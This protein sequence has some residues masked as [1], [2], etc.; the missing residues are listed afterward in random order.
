MPFRWSSSF[1]S[2]DWSLA[3]LMPNPILPVSIKLRP[4]LIIR[5][6]T[7]SKVIRWFIQSHTALVR[8]VLLCF[9]MIRHHELLWLGNDCFLMI[10]SCFSWLIYFYIFHMFFISYCSLLT[11]SHALFDM[12]PSP[13][14]H[15][16]MFLCFTLLQ[17]QVCWLF[18][19]CG[20]FGTRVIPTI[21]DFLD[22]IRYSRTL[23]VLVYKSS[24]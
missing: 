17:L 15:V 5:S 1:L 12:L 3:V 8:W 9:V 22:Y 7:A 18:W 19:S 6:H 24:R 16:I 21:T 10:S 11:I 20:P 14:A 2:C 13:A 4:L 23:V